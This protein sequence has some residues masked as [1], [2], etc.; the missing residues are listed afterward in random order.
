MPSKASTA[1]VPATL[2]PEELQA[3][4]GQA[5]MTPTSSGS[6]HRMSLKS[7][8]LVTDPGQPNEESWPPA[9][10][11]PTMTVR[12]VKPPVYYTQYFLDTKEENGAVSPLR[13]G[14]PDLDKKF[15]KK[16]DN[17][18]EQAND[19]WANFEV[20]N[21]VAAAAK[22]IGV[23]AKFVGDIKLQILPEDGE[24]KGDEPV[25]TLTLSTTSALDFRGTSRNPSG[26]VVQEKNFITQLGEL[27]QQQAIE[28]GVTDRGK[29]AQAILQAMTALELGGVV[30]EIYLIQTSD[31]ARPSQPWTVV[32]FRPVYIE[33]GTEAAA[34]SAGEEQDDLT[35]N[36]DDIPF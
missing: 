23:K 10:K 28:R 8:I 11:G 27:A 30:A 24:F 17:A 26:G 16:Y 15:V 33:T 25:Y 13:I 12:I 34:L 4:L 14:R 21:E 29:L 18:E 5:G 36:S 6:F 32:A 1:V 19:D 35:S 22:E 7:G 9:R 31:P 2:S 20:W 3:L